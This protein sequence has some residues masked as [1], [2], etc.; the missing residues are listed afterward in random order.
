MAEPTSSDSAAEPASVVS[1][2][3][4]DRMLAVRTE[5]AR[6]PAGDGLDE[7]ARVLDSPKPAEI[8]V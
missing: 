3:G 5:L 8:I 1:L 6:R 4:S 2:V 7:L